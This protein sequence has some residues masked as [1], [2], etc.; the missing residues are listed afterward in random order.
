M[1]LKAFVKLRLKSVFRELPI[2]IFTFAI[3]PIVLSSLYGYFQKDMFSPKNEIDKIAICIEDKDNSKLSNEFIKFLGSNELKKFID[4]KK[5]KEKAIEEVIIPKG[6]EKS[7]IEDKEIAIK[8]DEREKDKE[9]S[10]KILKDIIDNYNKELKN[11]LTIGNNINKMDIPKEK[12]DLLVKEISKDITK[13]YKKDA[14][15]NYIV[16]STRN[17]TSYEY[18]S[19]SILSFMFIVTVM[20]L[21]NRYYEEKKK[22]IFQRTLSTSISK[23]E[24]FNYSLISWYIFAVLF[25]SIYVLSYRFLGLSFKGNIGLLLLI[26]LTKSLLEVAISSVVIAFFKEQKMAVIF[27]NTVLIISVSLGG[28]FYPLEKVINSFNKIFRAISNF[29]PNVLII[30]AYKSFLIYNSFEAIKYYLIT[31]ILVSMVLYSVSLLKINIKWGD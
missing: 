9:V 24:Y 18:Y 30:K 22:G 5:N 11:N 26:V 16:K 8:I 15:R 28:V 14:I 23:T 10:S 21:C 4:I 29:A 7:I 27:L 2:M 13:I 25:N 31:F 19:V 3:F 6:Y 17:L 20:S 12:K 1:M